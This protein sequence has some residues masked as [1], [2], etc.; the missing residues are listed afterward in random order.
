[1][2]PHAFFHVCICLLFG[3]LCCLL[4]GALLSAMCFKLKTREF[5]KSI[6]PWLGGFRYL[7]S[8]ILDD[9]GRA[10]EELA[11]IANGYTIEIMKQWIFGVVSAMVECS[12]KLMPLCQLCLLTFF[13]GGA[14]I[15]PGLHLGSSYLSI[16]WI[17]SCLQRFLMFVVQSANRTPFQTMRT[18]CCLCGS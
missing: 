6:W 9:K 14:P 7:G 15:C 4:G 3:C 1:M 18:A 17:Q 2:S 11:H 5:Q 13:Q 8:C 10:F 12:V 16:E